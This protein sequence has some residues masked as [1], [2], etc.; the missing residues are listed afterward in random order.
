MLL[1]ITLLYPTELVKYGKKSLIVK[2]G[3][4]NLTL[5]QLCGGM[6]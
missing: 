1:I 3:W 2:N 6:T 4:S 5:R